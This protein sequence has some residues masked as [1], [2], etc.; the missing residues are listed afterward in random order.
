LYIK[1]IK[2]N[3]EKKNLKLFTEKQTVPKT[4]MKTVVQGSTITHHQKI[5]THNIKA[6]KHD[7]QHSARGDVT[8]TGWQ[9]IEK[10]C[11]TNQ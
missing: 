7:P 4:T 5:A 10:A 6:V 9:V 11:M 8:Q 3:I 1:T 2:K